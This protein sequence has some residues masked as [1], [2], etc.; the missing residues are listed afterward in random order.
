MTRAAWVPAAHVARRLGLDV[1]TVRTWIAK[2][3]FR[4]R[5]VRSYRDGRSRWFVL[6]VD[7]VAWEEGREL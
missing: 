7:L 4:G 6:R 1:R 2:R 3:I 5:R